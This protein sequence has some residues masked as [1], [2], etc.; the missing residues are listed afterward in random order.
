[1]KIIS[2][3]TL[4]WLFGFHSI[5]HSFFVYLAW[6]K[7]YKKLPSFKETICIL[8]HDIG[9]CGMNYI[10]NQNH[11]GHEILGAKIAEKLFGKKEYDLCIN[12]RVFGKKLEM[13]D[14]YSHVI[15]P[16]FLVKIEHIA[17]NSNKLMS[18]LEWKKYTKERWQKRLQG[19]VFAG[20]FKDCFK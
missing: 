17:E 16:L 20:Q 14:E 4:S 15:M 10:T 3:G 1:M 9:Y 19:Q 5:I 13:P 8:L 2:E 7:L 12:H 6:I 18:A 11:E